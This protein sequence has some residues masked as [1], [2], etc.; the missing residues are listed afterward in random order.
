MID[1]D[2][3]LLTN[4]QKLDAAVDIESIKDQL[5]KDTANKKL[6]S[7]LWESVDQ[8]V[9]LANLADTPI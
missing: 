1:A 4:A 7:Q 6:I 9:N 3:T 5:A 8:F 2:S